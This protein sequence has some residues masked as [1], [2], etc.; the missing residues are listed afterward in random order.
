MEHIPKNWLI[1]HLYFMS[2]SEIIFLE[3]K[4]RRKILI[5][6][7][8]VIFEKNLN[9]FLGTESKFFIMCLKEKI[10][11]SSFLPFLND[12]RYARATIVALCSQGLNT[13][14]PIFLF[15]KFLISNRL[16]QGW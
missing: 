16:M 13:L 7:L 6:Q 2:S 11:Q 14:K 12:F 4:H 3:V 10:L 5:N 8:P 15:L 1:S 9:Y